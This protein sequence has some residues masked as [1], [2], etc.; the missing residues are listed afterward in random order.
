MLPLGHLGQLE[1]FLSCSCF[2]ILTSNRNSR[3]HET[4]SILHGNKCVQS[5]ICAQQGPEK[6]GKEATE[7]PYGSHEVLGHSSCALFIGEP[8]KCSF[9][10]CVLF[11]TAKQVS[12]YKIVMAFSVAIH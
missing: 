3:L 6:E 2:Q 12:S 7:Q 8:F 1:V 5:H 9:R 11:S 4:E 10:T